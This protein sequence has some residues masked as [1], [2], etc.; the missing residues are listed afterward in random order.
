MKKLVFVF[1]LVWIH[2]VLSGFAEGIVSPNKN[3]YFYDEV[4]VLSEETKGEIFFSNRLLYDDC[5][6][7]IVVVV[8]NSTGSY[9]TEEYCIELFNQ[10]GI[11]DAEKNNGFLL[12]L[13]IQDD[14]YYA[15]PGSGL[16]SQ[17]PATMIKTMFDEYL[18]NDFAVK[19]YDTGVR[20][21]YEAAF[22]H[23]AE[24][25]HSNVTIQDGIKA[26]ENYKTEPLTVDI[27]LTKLSWNELLLLQ[28][29]IVEEMQNRLEP[30]MAE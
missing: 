25:N 21:F 3:F 1:V 20:K 30:S 15:C 29:K 6:A 13:A 26:Y 2:S 14:D 27:D 22:A 8:I 10:W 19:Q 7:Q 18:E 28:Q 11:G 16:E 17:F 9:S 12:L 24:V 4:G 23:I 5:G